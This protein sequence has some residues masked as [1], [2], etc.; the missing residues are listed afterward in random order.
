MG[1]EPR[2]EELVGEST[3]GRSRRGGIMSIHVN[4]CLTLGFA[5]S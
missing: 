5:I 3:R 2:V 1:R 4:T